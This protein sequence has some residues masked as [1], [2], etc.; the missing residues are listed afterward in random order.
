M[1]SALIREIEEKYLENTKDWPEFR[2]GDTI[3]VHVKIEERGKERIQVFEGAVIRI[4]GSGTGKTF[5]VRK[6]SYGVGME[7]TFPWGCPSIAKIEVAKRGKVR[8]AKLYYLRERKGK[9]ARIKEIK[10]W[11]LKKRA[12]ESAAA[13]ESKEENQ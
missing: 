8:R 12:A 3:R 1:S 7:R 11:E 10:E 13:K 2:V 4:K 5:T 9:A 6:V